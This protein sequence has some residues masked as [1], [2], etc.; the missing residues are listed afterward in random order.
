VYCLNPALKV[1]ISE[2]TWLAL[3]LNGV[4]GCIQFGIINMC[5]IRTKFGTFY[6]QMPACVH[7]TG[8]E[9][10]YKEQLSYSVALNA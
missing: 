4:R 9:D 8:T 6:T 10:G 2:A 3:G 7:V 1:K 5:V